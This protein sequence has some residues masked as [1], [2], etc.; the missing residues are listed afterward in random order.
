MRPKNVSRVRKLV[1]LA[2][3]ALMLSGA[4]LLQPA[5]ASLFSRIFFFHSVTAPDLDPALQAGSVDHISFADPAAMRSFYAGRHNQPLWSGNDAERGQAKAVEDYLAQ[6]WSQGLNP[7]N[8]HV[9]EIQPLLNAKDPASAVSLE[10]LTTDAVIRFGHDV[11]GM[12]LKPSSIGQDP[13]YWRRP[14]DAAAVLDSVGKAGD[15]ADAV[16]ALAPQD[17]TY[18]ALQAEMIRLAGRA[19]DRAHMEQIAANLERLRW[20]DQTKPDRYVLVN[21]PQQMLWGISNGK[22]E[23]QMEVVVGQVQR[24]T[25]SFKTN[26]T[27]I[28]F[29]PRWTVP[30]SIKMKD[31][32]PILVNDPSILADKGIELYR[33]DHGRHVTVDPARVNWRGVTP[34]DMKKFHMVQTPGYD[35]S[36]GLIRVLM[37]DD[38]DIYLHDTNHRDL[39]VKNQ[40]FFS[41]GCVRLSDPVTMAHFVLEDRKG[42]NDDEMQKLVAKG[43]QTDIPVDHPLPIYLVYLTVWMGPKGHLVYGQDVYGWDRQL[44]AALKAARAYAVPRIDSGKAPSY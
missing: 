25:M 11:T 5:K 43:T 6:S 12:R 18:K 40:R 1:L 23:I 29:N 7:E 28:R 42:W 37:P 38:Y 24:P 20:L 41:S 39:F 19:P 2:A 8:Y 14:M 21:I 15:P 17:K 36:L 33:I 31:F 13:K 9:A 4:V 16:T 34:D 27:G 35:N 32:L 30:Q 22:P 26:I 10:L 3:V 44:I